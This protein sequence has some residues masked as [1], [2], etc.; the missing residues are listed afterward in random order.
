M[1]AYIGLVQIY[2]QTAVIPNLDT[3]GGVGSTSHSSRVT[4]G[5]KPLYSLNRTL[6]GPQSQSG[7][8]SL[9]PVEIITPDNRLIP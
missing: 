1:K 3:S 8:F 2:E 5:K 4:P 7:S 9:S 6:R